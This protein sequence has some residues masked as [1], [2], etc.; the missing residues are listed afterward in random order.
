MRHVDP[1]G[2]SAQ[3][4]ARSPFRRTPLM[5]E[6]MHACILCFASAVHYPSVWSACLFHHAF[7][8]TLQLIT[9]TVHIC[10]TWSGTR[11][12]RRSSFFLA[13]GRIALAFA[14]ENKQ[15]TVNL[16]RLAAIG[17]WSSSLAVSATSIYWITC[18]STTPSVLNYVILTFLKS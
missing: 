1:A 7:L 9:S 13:Q 4:T 17:G 14:W 16:F 6:H 2:C 12:T 8:E 10:P 15:G 11:R 18:Y 5:I 3:C